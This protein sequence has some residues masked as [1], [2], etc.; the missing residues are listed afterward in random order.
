MQTYRGTAAS[1]GIAIGP[2]AIF[3]KSTL[4]IQERTLNEQAVGPEVERFRAAVGLSKQQ[5]EAIAE[6]AERDTGEETAAIF[7]AHLLFLE[8]PAIVDAVEERVREGRRSAEAVVAEVIEEQ[9]ATLA[10][11]ADAYFAARAADVRDVGERLIRNLLHPAGE[12]G[13]GEGRTGEIGEGIGGGGSGAPGVVF[14]HDLAPSDTAQLDRRMVLAFVTE[15]GGP[16]SHTAIMARAMGIPAVVGTGELL[17]RVHEGETVIVDGGE[18]TVVCSPETGLLTDYRRRSDAAAARSRGRERLRDL[19]AETTD[20][21]RVELAANIGH[22]REAGPALEHGPD[23]VGLYRTE[24]LFLDRSTVPG[25]DEQ[26]E[27][28]RAVAE[29]FGERPVIIRTLDIGGDKEVPALGL[30]REAN[31]FLGWR[32]LR[33]SLQRRDLFRTQLRALWRAAAHGHILVMFPMVATVDEVRQ[34]KAAL[35]QAREELVAE[36]KP[37]G[38]AI[39]VGIM[40]ETPAAAV[41]ADIL[42]R[43]VDFFSLG[44]NDL[45]Q[46]TLA[47]DRVNEKVAY[48][49]DPFHPAVLRLIARTVEAAHAAGIWCGMCGEMAGMVEAAPFLVGIGLDELSMNA[50]ALPLLKEAIRGMT[51]ARA[52]ELARK[53]L[54]AES[55][56][57]AR[58]IL[59]GKAGD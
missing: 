4:T 7:R 8:D 12:G 53:A 39:P 40:V 59:A 18:G 27:A 54:D 37:C 50:P 31:P 26:Y 29:A 28:Y 2:A 36:G 46:Y 17:A 3:R 57:R 38:S 47:A 35:A 52:A 44:T 14:A 34:A 51:A 32:A 22:P 41:S 1:P 20:G 24:F 45:I 49:Y 33:I 11:L 43:E 5:L 15:A 21:R 25:E 13:A 10:A 6:R 56:A 16:T 9:A 23:G 30:E 58:E 42:A 55:G 48:L 19:P